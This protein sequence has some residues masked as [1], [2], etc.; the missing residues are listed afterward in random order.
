MIINYRRSARARRLRLFIRTGSAGWLAARHFD[1][2]A[3]DAAALRPRAGQL[4]QVLED[5][6]ARPVAALARNLFPAPF[7]G[8]RCPERVVEMRFRGH[9]QLPTGR[10]TSGPARRQPQFATGRLADEHWRAMPMRAK[11]LPARPRSVR[12]GK[13]FNAATITASRPLECDDSTRAHTSGL[14]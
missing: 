4:G 5:T 13:F 12:R 8:A 1:L 3:G 2:Q 14:K 10:K 11:K 6:E 7:L 9:F